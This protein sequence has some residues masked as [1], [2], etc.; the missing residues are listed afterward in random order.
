MALVKT[1]ELAAKR[2]AQKT[3]LPAVQEPT[4]ARPPKRRRVNAKPQT[5][6][7]RLSAAAQELAG[8]VT[9]AAGAAEEL[10]RAMQQISTAAEE[11]AGAAQQSLSAITALSATFAQSRERADLSQSQA[12]ALQAQVAEA[13]GY[14]DASVSAIK[15]NAARQVKLVKVIGA[16][17][18][19]AAA[20][21]D[22]TTAAADIADQTN[23]LA[24]NAAIEASRAGD[25]GRGFAVVAD[26]VRGLAEVTE[27]RSREVK[28]IAVR[29]A[30]EVRAI[31]ARLQ[32]T[33][34]NAQSE[35]EAG[36]TV[37]D[38]LLAIRANLASLVEGSKSI[39]A[40]AIE[41]EGAMREAQTG[42]ETI[43]SAA[44]EQASAATEAQRA[45]QQQSASLD[46]SSQTAESLA[47][48]ADGLTDTATRVDNDV[49]AEQVGAAAEELSSAVQELAGAAAQILAAVDQIG[50][51]AQ[52]QAAAT[53]QASAAM[54]QIQRAAATTRTAAASSASQVDET[55]AL[56][57]TSR[58]AIARLGAGVT[59]A[60]AETRS[61]LDLL[62][63]L[64]S[65]GMVIERV[66]ESM[67]LAAVQTT[68][69]AVSGGV[70]AA[71]AGE[72]G[73]GFAAVSGDIR[74]LA[75][76]SMSSADRAKEIVRHM[77]THTGSVRRDLDQIV[78]V[79]EAELERTR[80]TDQ[81]IGAVAGTANALRTSSAQVAEV[82]GAAERSVGEILAGMREVA[83]AADQASAAANQAAS[84]AHQQAQGAEDL[85][86]STEEIASLAS[87]MLQSEPAA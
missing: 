60:A 10:S 20:I 52:I 53:Q 32:T 3:P 25:E 72:Q 41:A 37:I 11:A 36:G 40:A 49:L 12:V 80:Q 75:N 42:A 34:A 57:D 4:K 71:R 15:S 19:Q 83:T 16:L 82:A 7:E 35:A 1:S 74:N 43:A 77:R 18:S 38:T 22:I 2:G 31:S 33:A 76:D 62:D 44:E 45:V 50:R 39:L 69:L 87:E 24:L 59:E 81:R 67:A 27:A 17:E 79:M 64:E 63:A 54:E 61:V 73:R 29:I 30:E 9:Q 78:V 21:A 14:I 28:D 65:S 23:L 26:E 70:E 8:G 47:A 5:A 84:A 58:T 13:A 68:M 55:Q 56:L 48:L 66:V 86:A 6:G 85:A 51:G 46:E